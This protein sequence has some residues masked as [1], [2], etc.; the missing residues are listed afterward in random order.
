MSHSAYTMPLEVT[1][2]SEADIQGAITTIQL[3]FAEDPYNLWVYDDRSKVNYLSLF[4]ASSCYRLSKTSTDSSAIILRTTFTGL[5]SFLNF[6][7][8]P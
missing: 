1:P 7:D 8:N 6:S 3:A 2:L 4:K 5:S